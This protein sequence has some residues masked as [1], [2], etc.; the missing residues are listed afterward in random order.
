MMRKMRLKPNPL[1]V[2]S[3]I[4]LLFGAGAAAPRVVL[5]ELYDGGA[6]PG[7]PHSIR[8]MD[9]L[10]TIHDRIDLA[11]LEYPVGIHSDDLTTEEG[12]L[13]WQGFYGQVGIP[14]TWFDGVLNQYRSTGTDTGDFNAFENFYQLRHVIQSP[15]RMTMDGSINDTDGHI[16]TTIIVQEDLSGHGELRFVFCVAEDS[17]YYE[18]ING[19]NWHNHIVRDMVP[20][21]EG[22]VISLNQGDTLVVVR[23]FAVDSTWDTAHLSAVGFV[24]DW[25]TL[26]VLQAVDLRAELR[27]GDSDGNGTV[28]PSDGYVVLNYL[29]DGPPPVS[30]RVANVN[31][32]S[33]I[34]PADAF[35]LLNY[36]GSGPDLNCGPCEFAGQR[37]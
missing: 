30:C 17:I 1:V 36:L 32:D 5:G 8:A 29:G 27:C 26:E 13:R 31:G 7:C 10:S 20:D 6:C 9:S 4:L 11:I 28:T 2:T 15:L 21:E 14:T 33:G 34:T 23:D 18:W 19:I 12:Q 24:Q 16:E 25:T 3:F 35:H 22:E 37:G